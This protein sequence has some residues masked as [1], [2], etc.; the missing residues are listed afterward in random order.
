MTTLPQPPRLPAGYVPEPISP[1]DLAASTRGVTTQSQR[2]VA[3]LYFFAGLSA[4][5]TLV[6]AGLSVWGLGALP[7]FFK[8]LSKL[9]SSGSAPFDLGAALP[10]W[11]GP[12]MV[13]LTLLGGF[14]GVWAILVAARSIRAVAQQ[15]LE[16]S[17]GHAEALQ[18]AA[19]T[20]RPW[21]VLGQFAPLLSLVVGLLYSFGLVAW[22]SR[23]DPS[24]SAELSFGLPEM[25]GMSLMSVLQSAPSLIINFLILAAIGRWL[26][27]V[28]TRSADPTFPVRPFA[29]QVDPWL[30]L[31]MILLIL[32]AVSLLFSAIML[33]FAPAMLGSAFVSDSDLRNLGL[34]LTQVK[35]FFGLG[36]LL[37]LIGLAVYVLLA[38]LMAWSRTFALDVAKVLDAHAQPLATAAYLWDGPEQVVT[39][40]APK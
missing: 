35:W 12:S 10:A 18:S 36:A 32:G 16:P 24:N 25:L 22:M 7:D 27:A 17:Q 3:A 19:R 28:V 30:I 20:V 38:C 15:T 8:R 34:T 6:G 2:I 21:L 37:C 5:L 39:P 4:L 1:L 26:A 9:D 14:L 40:R 13:I 31:T 29:R 23:L 33:L 11:L